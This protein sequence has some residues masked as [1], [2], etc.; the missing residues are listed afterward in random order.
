[1]RDLELNRWPAGLRMHGYPGNEA[2]GMTTRERLREDAVARDSNWRPV[3]VKSHYPTF[4][5]AEGRYAFRS[6]G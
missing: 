6:G 4:K 3:L 5:T 2:C 1:M